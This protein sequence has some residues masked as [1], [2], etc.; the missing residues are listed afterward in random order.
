MGPSS[1]WR[2]DQ[3]VRGGHCGICLAVLCCVTFSEWHNV[4]IGALIVASAACISVRYFARCRCSGAGRQTCWPLSCI[5]VQKTRW[6][7][8]LGRC[9]LNV[10]NIIFRF[11]YSGPVCSTNFVRHAF[12]SPKNFRS[13][14]FRPNSK[15][16]IVIWKLCEPYINKELEYL[17]NLVSSFRY[18][19]LDCKV[20][21]WAFK[22]KLR[23]KLLVRRLMKYL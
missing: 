6:Q 15:L 19:K 21:E 20:W 5:Y 10:V 14:D 1:W 9:W 3:Q 8:W 23:M 17:K 12:L 7:R 13:C 22:M 18:C 2:N 16:H 11:S 4:F